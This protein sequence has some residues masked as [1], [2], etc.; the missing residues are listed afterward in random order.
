ML[1]GFTYTSGRECDVVTMDGARMPMLHVQLHE[2]RD[3]DAKLKWDG[4][5]Q[6]SRAIPIV[7]L[8]FMN[9]II[10]KFTESRPRGQDDFSG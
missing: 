6:L 3:V 2:H 5:S 8:A 1:V 9:S 10:H 4:Y 7:A